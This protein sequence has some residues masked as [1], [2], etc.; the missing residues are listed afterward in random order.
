MFTSGCRPWLKSVACLS[1]LL[2]RNTAWRSTW[3]S[4]EYPHFDTVWPPPPHPPL[5][6]NPGC[7]SV[8]V[9]HGISH[10]AYLANRWW[11]QPRWKMLIDDESLVWYR[12]QLF[13]SKGNKHKSCQSFWKKWTIVEVS[14]KASVWRLWRV[15]RPSFRKQIWMSNLSFGSS[16]TSANSL[17][18]QILSRL[19]FAFNKVR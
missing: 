15:L 9:N 8:E 6:K 17:W 11:S 7:A 19:H 2:G 14:W 10:Y 13:I 16:R 1:T 5:W 4:G 3:R 12:G 18:T